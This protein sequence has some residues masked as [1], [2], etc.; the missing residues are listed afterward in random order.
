M[1]GMAGMSWHVDVARCVPFRSMTVDC[2]QMLLMALER[3]SRGM[4]SSEES[5]LRALRDNV[6]QCWVVVRMV[7]S[8]KDLLSFSQLMFDFSPPLF[9]REKRESKKGYGQEEPRGGTKWPL[10]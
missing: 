1:P 9:C 7:G 8:R 10:D 2:V 4:P 5:G 3:A 6:R